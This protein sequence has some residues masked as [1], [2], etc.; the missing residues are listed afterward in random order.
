[1]KLNMSLNMF[2]VI[3]TFVVLILEHI[4]YKSINIKILYYFIYIYYFLLY[5]YTSFYSG[6]MEIHTI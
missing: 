3:R 4:Y 6:N 2:C 1:M 5:R